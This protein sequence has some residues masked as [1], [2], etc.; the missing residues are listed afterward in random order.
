MSTWRLA[1]SE[2]WIVQVGDLL[3]R[4]ASPAANL[5]TARLAA[6]ALDVSLAGNHEVHMLPTPPARTA[7]RSPRSR[8]GDGPRERQRSAT[9][10]SPPDVG[11]CGR[12]TA[13][14]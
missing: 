11:P 12:R 14:W 2:F 4:N 5:A 9:G 13:A 1:A 7:Q 10:W 6:D 3:D 8:H